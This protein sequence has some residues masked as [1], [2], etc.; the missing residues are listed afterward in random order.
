VLPLVLEVNGRFIS[1]GLSEV[2]WWG[3]IMVS[4]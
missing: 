2:R 1:W 3:L 4:P